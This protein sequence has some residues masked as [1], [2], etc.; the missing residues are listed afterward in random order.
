MI[1]YTYI[2]KAYEST[3][4]GNLSSY[5]LL[6]M[7]GGYSLSNRVRIFGRIENMLDENYETA[8]GYESPDLSAYGGIELAI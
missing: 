2:G 5:S 7:S 3:S 8:A 1:S 6:N 4:V